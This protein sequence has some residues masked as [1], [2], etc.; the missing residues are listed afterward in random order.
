MRYLGS[1]VASVLLLFAVFWIGSQI[2]IM[3]SQG[4]NDGTDYLRG[5]KLDLCGYQVDSRH[6]LAGY[7]LDDWKGERCEELSKLD[8][9]VLSCL[10][11][12][13][14]VEIGEDCYS[15]CVRRP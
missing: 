11:A 8:R 13:D 2:A 12:A 6:S 15:D 4:S 14:A 9:C 7:A 3:V 10:E 1:L 5:R